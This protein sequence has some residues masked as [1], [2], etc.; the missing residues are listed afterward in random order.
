MHHREREGITVVLRRLLNSR[1]PVSAKCSPIFSGAAHAMAAGSRLPRDGGSTGTRA[2]RSRLHRQE[3]AGWPPLL[4]PLV[5]ESYFLRSSSASSR[6]NL[7]C[8]AI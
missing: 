1:P 3:T 7:P 6:I 2:S 4:A 8:L 5:F